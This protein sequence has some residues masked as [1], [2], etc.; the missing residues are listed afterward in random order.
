MEVGL[1]VSRLLFLDSMLHLVW[2]TP[3]S[4]PRSRARGCQLL[5]VLN[6]HGICFVFKVA[7]LTGV[8]L[9]GVPMTISDVEWRKL[10]S[11][12]KKLS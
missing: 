3:P 10:F 1:P 5:N 9:I 6:P 8:T 11:V 2:A 12:W 4:I 7:M